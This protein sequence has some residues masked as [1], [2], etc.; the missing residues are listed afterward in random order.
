MR[1]KPPSPPPTPGAAKHSSTWAKWLTM[2]GTILHQLIAW[3]SGKPC[4][5]KQCMY[6]CMY[7]WCLYFKYIYVTYVHNQYIEYRCISWNKALHDF[8]KRLLWKQDYIFVLNFV[9]HVYCILYTS[10]I[11][12]SNT[13]DSVEHR[14]LHDRICFPCNRV[15]FHKKKLT[16][17][18]KKVVQ[19]QQVKSLKILH[20]E[21]TFP[22]RNKEKTIFPNIL[23]NK[24]GVPRPVFDEIHQVTHLKDV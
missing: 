14:F 21:A 19:D 6:V 5:L 23:E 12:S 9:P 2:E 13:H 4:K 22:P 18:T 8:Q 10:H 17:P 11:S 20:R 15:I 7:V 24:G 1:T 16:Q 3:Q